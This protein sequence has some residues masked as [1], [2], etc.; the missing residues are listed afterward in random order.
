MPVDPGEDFI[1]TRY[2]EHLAEISH[3]EHSELETE[4]NKPPE[5]DTTPDWINRGRP[6]PV[7]EYDSSVRSSPISLPLSKVDWFNESRPECKY[8]HIDE[9]KELFPGNWWLKWSQKSWFYRK[10]FDWYYHACYYFPAPFE[11][12]ADYYNRERQGDHYILD[13]SLEIL[14]HESRLLNSILADPNIPLGENDTDE[15]SK[16]Y[17]VRQWEARHKSF[18][19]PKNINHEYPGLQSF[20]G[21]PWT[22]LYTYRHVVNRQPWRD[23]KLDIKKAANLRVPKDISAAKKWL[24]YHKPVILKKNHDSEFLI[25]LKEKLS[26]AGFKSIRACQKWLRR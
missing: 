6:L 18:C 5:P 21:F 20:W 13:L 14:L 24:V 3:L 7:L 22:D 25:V 26:V 12:R 2:K 10:V 15:D 23:Y 9:L 17:Y 8:M 16:R 4:E 11:S 1:V 19:H